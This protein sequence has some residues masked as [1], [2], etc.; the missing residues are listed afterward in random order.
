[1]GGRA[2]G[3]G[4]QP[5][6]PL[7]HH[8]GWWAVRHLPLEERQPLGKTVLLPERTGPVLLGER[9]RRRRSVVEALLVLRHPAR[10]GIVASQVGQRLGHHRPVIGQAGGTVVGRRGREQRQCIVERLRFHRSSMAI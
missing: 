6:H 9:P 7:P 1:M 3:T 10:D 5:R 8:S 4:Q 2:H